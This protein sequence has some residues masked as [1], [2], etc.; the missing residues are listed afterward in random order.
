MKSEIVRGERGEQAEA[1]VG[2]RGAVRDR[3]APELSWT[4][5]GGR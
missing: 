5:S 3:Q 4:L 2:R 1:D